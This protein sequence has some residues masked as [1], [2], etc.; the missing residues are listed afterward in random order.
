MAGR[1]MFARAVTET[2]RFMRLPVGAKYLYYELG[3]NADDDGFAE[4]WLVLRMT[5][6]EEADLRA[7]EQAGYVKVYGEDLVTYIVDWET[8]NQ[9]RKD[10][11]RES[12][13]AYLLNEEPEAA[14][15]GRPEKASREKAPEGERASKED[16]EAAEVLPARS[17]GTGRE[18]TAAETREGRTTKEML[19]AE[20]LEIQRQ[21]RRRAAQ[22]E[23]QRLREKEELRAA[24]EK[25]GLCF[26]DLDE[27]LEDG[28]HTHRNIWEI[29]R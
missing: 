27:P 7:L 8:N 13:Y 26:I 2:G 16:S 12:R 17:L 23:E 18:P 4:G 29:G 28:D 5:G 15:E 14:R 20:L 11:Y 3:M 6:Q 21:A 9:I 22:K 10:R 25:A 19:D 24:R 1:R